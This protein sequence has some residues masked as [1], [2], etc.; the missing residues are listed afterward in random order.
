MIS[1]IKN[2]FNDTQF[3]FELAKDQAIVRNGIHVFILLVIFLGQYIGWVDDFSPV[4]VT[5][6]IGYVVFCF[7]LT[8]GV[9]TFPFLAKSI[10]IAGML[11]DIL[12]LTV[13]MIVGG[14]KEAALYGLYLFV[15]IAN[16]LRFGKAYMQFANLICII[17]FSTVLTFGEFWQQHIVLGIGFMAW[18]LLIPFYLGT[19]LSRLEEAVEKAEAANNSKSMFVANMS[20]EIRTPLT[21][22]IGFSKSLKN[23]KLDAEK[24]DTAVDTIISNAEHLSSIVNDILDISKIEAGKLAIEIRPTSLFGIVQ[25]IDT[26]FR[27]RIEENGVEFIIEYHYP[28]PNKILTDSMRVKQVLMNLCSNAYKFTQSGKISISIEHIVRNNCLRF[29]VRD[30][31]IG[32]TEEQSKIIFSDFSQADVGTPRKYGGTGLGLSIS[33]H[34]ASLL[35][36]NLWLHSEINKGSVFS[37]TIDIGEVPQSNL[38][39]KFP[40]HLG[41]DASDLAE[42]NEPIDTPS[43]V[44]GTVLLVEDVADNRIFISSLL[45]DMGAIVEVAENGE[46]AVHKTSD[47]SYDLV[48]MDIQM[49]V[50]NGFDA[51]ER[52]RKNNYQK[53]VVFIT[54]NVIQNEESQC[55]R[56]GCQGFLRK[57]ID[58]YKFE[59]IISSFLK[60]T[61]KIEN[62]DQFIGSEIKD[63]ENAI[64][65]DLYFKDIEKY[66]PMVKDFVSQLHERLVEIHDD[67]ESRDLDNL[68]RR[69]HDLK[70]VGG[71]MGYDVISKQVVKMEKALVKA[72][73][74]QLNQLVQELFTIEKRIIKGVIL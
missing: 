37:F 36:G 13:L 27:D 26:L 44:S 64:L 58:E 39:Y 11:S 16:G 19:L 32:L 25:E 74:N 42:V 21:A 62:K 52:M 18:L 38:E 73:Y 46:V 1:Q 17:C 47:K 68:K 9:F 20:H 40:Q 24:T 15:I 6:G 4:I 55:E 67:L 30:T 23:K 43:K 12:I 70:G 41:E 35:K 22:M 28:L 33:K 29:D 72:E 60:N 51:L 48:L 10:S 3:T 53:P 57:P 66:K 50:L 45:E 8:L 54:A 49:P 34:L 71:N 69:L 59:K 63:N 2:I 7:L 5:L 56:L 61:K 65:S 14:D 31:G